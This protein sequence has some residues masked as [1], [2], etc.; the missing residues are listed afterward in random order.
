MAIVNAGLTVGQ[1]TDA[2]SGTVPAGDVISTSPSGGV[3]VAPGTPVNIV[4]S[5]GNP[6]VL[7]SI[8]V[9]PA[10][11]SIVMGGTQQFT[12]TG[13][14][15]DNSMQNLTTQVAWGSSKAAIATVT[16]GAAGGLATGAGIGS[17]TISATLNSITGSTT[18]TVT[19]SPCDLNQDGL[20]T[21]ID[22][23]AMINQAL[24]ESQAVN[25]LNGDHV[26]N[27]VDIQ[28][29]INAALHLGCTV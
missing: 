8:K 15:S 26:V 20:F 9:T 19:A 28:I 1:V 5:I 13:T 17:S 6:L 21:V 18:L 11:P 29:V 23:Q 27:A 7:Q 24:G 2:A 16:S 10:N 25:D 3:S 4:V 12:A 14:Y 22:V